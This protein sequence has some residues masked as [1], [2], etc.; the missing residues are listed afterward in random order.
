VLLVEMVIL[1]MIGADRKP[2]GE[3][4]NIYFPDSTP[5]GSMVQRRTIRAPLVV[6]LVV[7]AAAA[8]LSLSLGSREELIPQRKEFSVFPL[9][10]GNWKGQS[11]RLEKIYLDILKLDDYVMTDYVGTDGKAVNFYVAYY[12]SQTKGESAH[13]PRSCLPGGGWEIDSLEQKTLGVTTRSGVPLTVNRVV[14][15]KGE[16]TQLVYYWFQGR[17]RIITNEYMVK[18]Y[19]FWDALTRNRTD[20]ALVRLTT[21]V[22]PAEDLQAAER[23]LGD[24]A[25]QVSGPLSQYVPD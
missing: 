21:M 9:D 13:S 18:W 1:S 22:G 3:V 12:A 11:E 19:L 4:F 2:L 8:V 20:G 15:K 7:I 24:F 23:R 5:E 17:G 14:I 25:Q 16:Y 6:S 10:I